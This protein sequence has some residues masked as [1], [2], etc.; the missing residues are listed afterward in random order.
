MRNYRIALE[1]DACLSWQCRHLAGE[2]GTALPFLR[3][4]SLR[5]FITQCFI[6]QLLLPNSNETGSPIS[7]PF[8]QASLKENKSTPIS[9]PRDST[10]TLPQCEVERTTHLR[11]V[12]RCHVCC[13]CE[14]CVDALVCCKPA[15]GVHTCDRI[16]SEGL[17]SLCHTQTAYILLSSAFIHQNSV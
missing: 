12:S 10:V 8:G 2:S 11:A 6:Q 14:R 7:A 17:T 9:R 4:T 16:H 13:D 1:I 3:E 5:R 15:S